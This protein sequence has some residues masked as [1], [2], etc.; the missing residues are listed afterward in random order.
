[1]N[2]GKHVQGTATITTAGSADIIATPGTLLRM[3]MQKV[4]VS[5]FVVAASATLA[6]TDGTTTYWKVAVDDTD[7][8]VS[9][10]LDFGDKGYPTPRTFGPPR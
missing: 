8:G 3:S 1:M 6:I 5:C 9:W 7:G 10:E 2:Y 4:V